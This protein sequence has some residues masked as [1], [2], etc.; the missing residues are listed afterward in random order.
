MANKQVFLELFGQIKRDGADDLLKFLETTDFFTAPASTNFHSAYEGGLVDHSVKVYHRFL[1]IVKTEYGE[2][3]QQ[4]I[5]PESVAICALL[6]D[7]CKVNFYVLDYRN[8]KINGVWERKPYFAVDDKLPYGH[9]E[10]SVYIIN[11]FIKLTREEAMAIN[12]HMGAFDLRVKGG[13]YSL[14]EVFYKYP[15]ALL[16]HLADM[17]ATYLDEEKEKKNG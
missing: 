6:H 4:F 14:S 2:K 13:S 9:G 17:Q 8:V 12:W 16:F 15:T 5:S 10:K 11:G 3:W 7:I 1:Q